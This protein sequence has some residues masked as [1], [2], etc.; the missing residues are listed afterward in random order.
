MLE[1]LLQKRR[2]APRIVGEDCEYKAS[3]RSLA[4]FAQQADLAPA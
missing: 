3:K 2:L 1:L 4:L